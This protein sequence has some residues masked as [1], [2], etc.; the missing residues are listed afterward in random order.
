MDGFRYDYLDRFT[1]NETDNFHF[2]IRNGVK[3]KY[4]RNVFPTMTYP[5]HYTLITGLYPE[6]HGQVHNQFYDPDL[7]A[8]FW[9]EHRMDN[10]NPLWFDN[11]A[12]PIYVTNHK[13]GPN[14]K[15]G[16]VLFPTGLS[17]VKCVGPDYVIPNADP[18][19]TTKME[20]RIDYLMDWFT[21]RDNPINLGLLYFTEPDATAHIQGPDSEAVNNI[22]K[23]P[24][25]D[26][27]G[28]LKL[29][30]ESAGLLSSTNIIMTSD[31]GFTNVEKSLNID[32]FLDRSWYDEATDWYNNVV[33]QLIPKPGKLAADE[34]HFAKNKYMK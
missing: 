25:N 17:T 21:D 9:Y 33:L 32:D 30:L 1:E 16:S 12:E 15:S 10:F 26:A 22:I 13:A 20:T 24:L 34:K 7:H 2:F 28:Y 6:S 18:V 11:G 4:M 3:A 23:G 27:L 31:H 19:S 29:K 8:T 5:N 14:R